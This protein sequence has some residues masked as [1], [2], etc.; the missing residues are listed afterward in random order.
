[1]TLNDQFKLQVTLFMHDFLND[2][3]PKSFDNFFRLN[4]NV[5]ERETRQS[6]LFYTGK[7]RTNFSMR[8]PNHSFPRIWNNLNMEFQGIPYRNQFKRQ[9]RNH[10]LQ[11]YAENIMCDNRTCSQCYNAP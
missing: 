4:A 10:Y 1:M 11:N 5:V 3:L 9:C 7:P 2:H 6:H 8:L